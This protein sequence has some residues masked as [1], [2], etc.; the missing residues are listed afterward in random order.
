MKPFNV[1]S[2]IVWDCHLCYNVNVSL[3]N[4]EIKQQTTFK[5]SYCNH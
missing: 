2:A 1:M 4:D 3:F 5:C